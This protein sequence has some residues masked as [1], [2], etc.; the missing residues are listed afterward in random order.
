MIKRILLLAL[1]ALWLTPISSVDAAEIKMAYVDIPRVLASLD[2]S[3]KVRKL[4]EKK[5]ASRQREMVALE[6]EIKRLKERLEKR[7]H[8]MKPEARSEMAEKIR[9][10]FRH[11][12]R[13]VEDFQAQVDRENK[14]W[15][16][17]INKAM[18]EVIN[19]IARERKYTVVFGTGRVLYHDPSIDITKLV[20]E[21]LNRRT[22]S[23]F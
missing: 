21:R 17:K 8:M 10:K 3:T 4:L 14:L 15:T 9:R 6:K 7:K 20:L 22:K 11:F 19:K 1:F 2:A 5:V 18:K 13:L 12:Q 23:W 16:G